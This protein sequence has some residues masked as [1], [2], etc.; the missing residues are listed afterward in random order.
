MQQNDPLNRY[1]ELCLDVY[2]DLV[3]RGE[4]LWPDSQ[5]SEDL[6]ESEGIDP[7]P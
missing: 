1:L 6:V 4:W 7:H 2:R 3:D 5:K